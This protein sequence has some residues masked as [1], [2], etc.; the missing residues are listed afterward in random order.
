[1]LP[2]LSITKMCINSIQCTLEAKAAHETAIDFL[3][4]ATDRNTTVDHCFD[5]VG[6]DTRRASSLAKLMSLTKNNYQKFAYLGR[7]DLK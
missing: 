4:T 1:M 2:V 7:S 3:I 6:R 5:I